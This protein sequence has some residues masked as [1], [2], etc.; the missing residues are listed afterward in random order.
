MQVNSIESSIK[1]YKTLLSRTKLLKSKSNT[2]KQK[3]NNYKMTKKNTITQ[4]NQL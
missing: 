2:S 1:W 4:C 3:Q